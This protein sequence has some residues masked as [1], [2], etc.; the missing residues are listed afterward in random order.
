[1]VCTETQELDGVGGFINP[2]EQEIVFDVAFH[3]TF[4]FAVELVRVVL[5]R[6][7]TV[8]FHVPDYFSQ[9]VYFVGLVFVSLQVFLELPRL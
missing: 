9:G 3:A 1:M 4:V 7:A 8:P 2:D 6:Y 5:C